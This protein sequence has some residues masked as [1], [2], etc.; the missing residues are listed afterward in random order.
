MKKT[1]LASIILAGTLC[2]PTYADNYLA[3]KPGGGNLNP[4]LYTH[5]ESIEKFQDLRVGLS[6]HWGPSSL[7]GKEISW[8]RGEEIP[9][10][11]YDQFYKKFN[12][13]EFDANEW[14]QL[15][16]DGGMKY[17]LLTSKHHDGFSLWPSEY[18]DYNISNTPYKKDIVKALAEASQ[19]NDIVFGSYY[20]I[21]DWYHP[22]Y[23]PYGHG[24][25]GDLIKAQ[26]DSPNF[27]RYLS[28]MKSQL[29]ELVVDYGAEIIQLDGEW[30]PSW[31]H[32]IGS[33]LYLYLRKL[34]DKV[35]VNNRTDVGREHLNPETGM[36]DW[37]IYAGDF[38][39][40]ERMVDW[41]QKESH[42]FGKSDNPW[43]A[44]VTIDQ[45]QW[46]Y[47]E[48]P[49]LLS[50]DEVLVDLLKTIGD[51]GNYLINLGPEPDGQFNKEQVKIV[52]QVGSWIKA[53]DKAIYATR[54][55]PFSQ[56][57]V[58]TSTIKDN[59][60]YLF[61]LDE[62]LTKLSIDKV[63]KPV[64]KVST[65]QG[66]P[67]SFTHSGQS[68]DIKLPSTGADKIRVIKLTL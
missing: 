1:L 8:S 45:A 68:L 34:N 57:G 65:Y 46:S 25:P 43:Q 5:P 21:I 64:Q 62:S 42:V 50:A 17:I 56:E 30:D 61:V 66:K 58:Y 26:A 33:D 23:E 63:K 48:T 40:R 39:E 19:E 18:T 9:K 4:G 10:E 52:K 29:R 14:V 22:D 54:G 12:P 31:N 3:S 49:R 51:N 60:L 16:K 35:L 2:Q 13:T 53:H 20:S 27:N 59:H 7:G 11:T 32:Q 37:R 15:A 24:G 6:I 55:G 28:F 44:W 41:V 47:N 36:W 67:L 38:D